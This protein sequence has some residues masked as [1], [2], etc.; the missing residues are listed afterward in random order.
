MRHTNNPQ[1]S[2]PRAHRGGL[3]TPPCPTLPQLAIFLL[4]AR[5]K[6]HKMA[7]LHFQVASGIFVCLFCY[8]AILRQP[9]NENNPFKIH[10]L[11]ITAL[12]C[13]SQANDHYHNTK[14]I[15]T[16]WEFLSSYANSLKI[17]K[18]CPLKNPQEMP[19]INSAFC[20]FIGRRTHDRQHASNQARRA[21]GTHQ[22]GQNPQGR[23]VGGR[24]LGQCV[25]VASGAEIAHP[26]LQ[27][28]PHRRHPR[29]HH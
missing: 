17:R 9:E 14:Q 19:N 27:R 29:N 20:I 18:I 12:F 11:W 10:C 25:R 4:H 24:R 6:Q 15:I 21:A 3:K 7:N 13:P 16:I 26:V 2:T 23:N 5:P 28:H 22:F 8:M 1:Q